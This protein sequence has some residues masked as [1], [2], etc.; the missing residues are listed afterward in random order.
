MFA[1]QLEK[2]LLE[3]ATSECTSIAEQLYEYLEDERVR[4]RLQTWREE[5][6]PDIIAGDYET[7]KNA[8]K[9]L[10]TNR[11]ETEIWHW[12]KE[13]R[14]VKKALER[15]T[16]LVT[17]ESQYLHMQKDEI[18]L[19]LKGGSSTD[20]LVTNIKL[21]R[22]K[23]LFAKNVNGVGVSICLLKKVLT[24][25]KETDSYDTLVLMLQ[26]CKIQALFSQIFQLL[27]QFQFTEQ[28]CPKYNIIVIY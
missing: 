8:A 9:E 5:D 2:E 14:C 13:T 26:T 27:N 28:Q 7:T 16:L 19:R 18:E 24:F 3:E 11:L 22:S 17:K 1:L 23:F 12:E 25:P 4:E 6:A 15:F 21:Q 10:I 20:A